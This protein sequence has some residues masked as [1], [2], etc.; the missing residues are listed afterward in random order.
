MN[1]NTFLQK[2]KPFKVSKFKLVEMF[3]NKNYTH[4]LLNKDAHVYNFEAH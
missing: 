4:N 2:I 3:Y 1:I